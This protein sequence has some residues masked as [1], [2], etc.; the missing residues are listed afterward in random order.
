MAGAFWDGSGSALLGSALSGI[1][2]VGTFYATRWHERKI[3]REHLAYQAAEDI[4]KALLALEDAISP[5]PWEQPRGDW[6]ALWKAADKCGEVCMVRIA[7][8]SERSLSLAVQEIY[9]MVYD[10]LRVMQ[11]QAETDPGPVSDVDVEAMLHETIMYLEQVV[12]A[13]TNWRSLSVARKP[14][15]P[16][17]PWRSLLEP[18]PPRIEPG[19]PESRRGVLGWAR[20]PD[21]S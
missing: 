18:A 8:L 2:A 19:R 3:A 12:N 21:E 14:V 11:R 16:E 7:A 4:A 15:V 17:M 10:A 20:R 9:N 5:R 1:L 13:L 6:K